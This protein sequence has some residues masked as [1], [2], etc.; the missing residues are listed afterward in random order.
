[1]TDTAFV[2]GAQKLRQRIRTITRNLALPVLTEEIGDLLYMRTMR[3]FRAEVDPDG[4]RWADLAP[5]TLRR[6]ASMGLADTQKLERRGYM[7]KAI[8]KITGRT[9]DSTF[10]NTGAGVR[11]G[12]DDPGIAEYARAQNRGVK[13]RI[14]ARRFLGIGRLDV[15][16]VD[17]L[18]RRKSQQIGF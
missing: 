4:R 15:K 3:R 12:I 16:A 18:L 17:S 14:P 10:F 5:S 8:K 13:G 9:A 11:I 1:M 7:M 2:G 6:K